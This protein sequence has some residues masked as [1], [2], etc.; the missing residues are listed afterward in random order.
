MADFEETITS[1]TGIDDEADSE[2]TYEVETEDGVGLGDAGEYEHVAKG[3]VA[4][5]VAL[6][7]AD[8]KRL[9]SYTVGGRVDS[10]PTI[11][12]GRVLF[13]SAD[14]WVYCLRAADGKLA[15]RY[16]AAP[17][18]RRLTAFEQVE[19]VWPVS[20]S[21][22]VKGG[23]LY[24]VAGRSMF[25]DGGLRLWRLDPK[26]GRKLSETVLDDRDPATGKNLQ[27]KV[28]GL[29]MPTALPDVLSS[30]GQ[31]VYMR[32]QRFDMAGKRLAVVTPSDA[33]N[34]KG[35]GA[36]LL[37]NTGMLDGTWFHRGYWIYGKTSLSGAGGWYRAGQYAPA[38]RILVFD[39]S[40]V[41]GYG[42]KP[43]YFK[44]STPLEYH[45]FAAAKSAAAGRDAS[46]SS[47]AAVAPGKPRQAG[48]SEICITN[49]PSLNPAGKPL[50]VMAWIK[51]DKPN[52]IILAKGGG[53]HGY[54]LALKAGKPQFGI[55]VDQTAHSVSAKA[56]VV[57]KW[58][59]VAGVLT[60]DKELHIY[61]NGEPAGTGKASG[62]IAQDPNEPLALGTDA[63]SSVSENKQAPGFTGVIDEVRVFRGRMTPAEVKM[64]FA[65]KAD[66]PA[67]ARLVLYLSFDKGDARDDSG[68]GN[69][70]SVGAKV[71][72]GKYGKA[73][74]FA[75]R[76]SRPRRRG[77]GRRG[78]RR[79]AYRWS[80]QVPLHVRAAVL[81]G[82]TLFIAGPPDLVDE[83]KAFDGFGKA[84][85]QAKLAAQAAALAGEKGALLWAVGTADGKKLSEYK[86]DSLPVW[87][88]MAAAAGRLYLATTD[89]KVICF[90]PPAD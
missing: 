27:V 62:F 30:D 38:G 72:D 10:P 39:E 56:N 3:N 33:A 6:D 61:V 16:L 48:P 55:R 60:A 53:S 87:D 64:H 68:N 77:A 29:D 49:A 26:T 23:V 46:S 2:T 75:G 65:G 13:G 24:C 73:M 9:W 12:Q 34:Q 14:G 74:M 40:T 69:N 7:A 66:K 54:M 86:L 36:H 80:G 81:A 51:A 20:G 71:V 42:R 58:T 78:S 4:W 88:G 79:I 41:Y 85:I 32:A 31:F 63:G 44:W 82:K 35:V 15:W 76:R 83:E 84:G 52:G 43:E 25:L 18:D 57:G 22:L 89:G 5:N 17:L 11:Y 21:V 1:E 37:S 28:K 8:G 19:S 47:S 45:L 67:G 50:A 90:A 59:H 70:G